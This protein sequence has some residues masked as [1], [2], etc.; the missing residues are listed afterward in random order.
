M[1]DYVEILQKYWGYSSF[2]PLQGDIIA[3]VASGKDTLGLMPTGGG[4]SLTFQ[5]PTMAMD[6][7]CI[8]ITP[9]VALMKDQ[10][11]NLRQKGIKAAMIYS[12]MNRNEIIQTFD[13]CLYGNYKFLY[14]SPERIATDLFVKR[15]TSLKVCLIAVDE[16]H[17][18]SQWGYDFRPS[19]LQIVRIR[20][21]LPKVPILA[22]TAT[23]TP[24]VVDDIQEK[25]NFSAKNVFK[26]SFERQ[27]LAYVVRHSEDKLSQ[28]LHILQKV[29]GSSVVYVRNRKKT[30]EISDFLNQ[31]TISSDYFHAGLSDEEK[32][33]RQQAWKEGRCRVIVATNA[34]GMG[35][36][37]ADVRSVVHMDLPDSIEAYFQEAGRAG[38]D[39]KKAFAVLLFNNTDATRLKKRISDSFPQKERIFDVYEKLCCFLEIA[40]GF[41][42]NGVYAFNLQEFCTKFHLPINP[43]FSALKI[44]ELSG[45]L[46]LTEEIDNPSKLK[47]L[48]QKE[49]LYQLHSLDAQSDLILQCLLRSYSGLFAD[50]VHISE[51]LLSERTKI[52]RETIYEKLVFLSKIGVVKYI[53]FK[54]TP[55]IVFTKDRQ[56]LKYI[57]IPKSV[58]EER[59]ER[60]EKRISA[61]L[62]YA[63][64]KEF[65]RSRLL[66]DYFGEKNTTNCGCCDVCLDSKQHLSDSFFEK[67]TKKILE[68]LGN[69]HLDL[70]TLVATTEQKEQHVLSVLRHL[71]DNGI[72]AQD[73]SMKYYKP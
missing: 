45:Y 70:R 64:S 49:D 8:V 14:I 59:K 23:A 52:D 34:F 24:E 16:S 54:K 38:R 3:S 47:I 48:L 18:I 13:N 55:F 67:T 2:R 6:G 17:C 53:P 63:Q 35:I 56:P 12:A 58:Y 43:T 44:L 71:V 37:K 22:L 51:N 10:V 33:Q 46:E 73:E 29:R 15:I 1:Q 26:K 40:N 61:M 30:K 60:F 62:D 39:E 25:L 4:K 57:V 11:A 41:G 42:E 32:D 66:L 21:L 50:S 65:C 7:I 27:N 36:D 19:Y 20:E 5:V 9:L 31:N 68:A 69:H 28:L 72:V